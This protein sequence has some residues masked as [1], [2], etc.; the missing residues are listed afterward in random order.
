MFWHF[1][2][3]VP[4]RSLFSKVFVIAST[5]HLVEGPEDPRRHL[6]PG[7]FNLQSFQGVLS[8]I[9][10]RRSVHYRSAALL[11]LP[12]VVVGFGSIYHLPDTIQTP[13]FRG[14]I[15]TTYARCGW[16]CHCI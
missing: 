1:F 13:S 8:N 16:V 12:H 3:D 10:P 9:L 6:N 11:K 7:P 4:A 14:A 15:K 2:A 5:V